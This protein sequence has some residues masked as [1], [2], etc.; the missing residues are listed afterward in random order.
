LAAVGAALALG[1]VAAPTASAADRLPDLGMARIGD[2]KVEMSGGRTLL[3]YTSIIVN[4]GA[5]PIVRGADLGPDV[6][7]R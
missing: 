1:A 6:L 3:R 4:A 5:G 2:V 7:R